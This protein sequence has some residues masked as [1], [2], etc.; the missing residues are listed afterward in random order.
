[1][2]LSGCLI[3]AGGAVDKKASYWPFDGS[4]YPQN[5]DTK[6]FGGL[7]GAGH[8]CRAGQRTWDDHFGNSHPCPFPCQPGQATWQDP[9][10]HTWPCPEDID[11]WFGSVDFRRLADSANS[12]ADKDKVSSITGDLP[13]LFRAFRYIIY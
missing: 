13:L 12:V 3:H 9:V 1:V 6:T 8:P 4:S 11:D 2:G 5:G 10:G 7:G